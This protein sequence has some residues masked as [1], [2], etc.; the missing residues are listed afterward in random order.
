MKFKEIFD[1]QIVLDLEGGDQDTLSMQLLYKIFSAQ[2][3][4]QA[5]V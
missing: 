1:D 3:G 2:M 5:F 4:P